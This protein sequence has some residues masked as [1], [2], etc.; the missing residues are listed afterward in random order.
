MTWYA[1]E[2]ILRASDAALKAISAS[3]HLAPFAYHIQSLDGHEWYRQE[4][5]HALPDGG[6]LMIRPVCGRSSHGVD[7][8]GVAALDWA[9]LPFDSIA[10]VLLDTSVAQQLSEYLDEESIPP[11]QLRKAIASLAAHL[12][13]PVLYYGCGMWGGSVDY[14]YSL[15]YE[16]M[17]SVFLTRSSVQFDGLGTEDSLRAGL[18][19]IGLNL[20]TTYFAPH[21]RSYPWQLHKLR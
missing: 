9:E 13:Q 20:P 2:I 3:S 5:L 1:D 10:E 8:H 11:L 18:A 16:P 15:V 19:K 21:T 12:N 4:Q 14:E 7:W 17:E 6:L